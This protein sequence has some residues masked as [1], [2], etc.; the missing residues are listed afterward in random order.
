MLTNFNTLG[1][2]FFLPISGAWGNSLPTLNFSLGF[3]GINNRTNNNMHGSSITLGNGFFKPLPVTSDR[4]SNINSKFINT[5]PFTTLP[6][7]NAKRNYNIN[8]STSLN[9]I[10]IKNTKVD[11]VDKSNYNIIHTNRGWIY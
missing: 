9:G 11:Y 7:I 1:N 5:L 6:V 10:K 8:Q 3:G 4:L 2:I